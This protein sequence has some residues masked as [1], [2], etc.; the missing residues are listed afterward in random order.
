MRAAALASLSWGGSFHLDI[1]AANPTAAA[2][3]NVTLYVVD[4]ERFGASLVIKAMDLSTLKTIAPMAFVTPDASNGGAYIRYSVTGGVRFR[5]EQVHAAK[6]D[7]HGL[8]PRPMV[9]AVFFDSAPLLRGAQ[10]RSFPLY[11]PLPTTGTTLRTSDA[12]LQALWDRAASVEPT[13]ARPF[14][15]EPPFDVIIEGAQYKGVSDPLPHPLLAPLTRP[16]AAPGVDRDAAD[17]GRDVGRP[18]RAPCPQRAARLRPLPAQRR[19]P[20]PRGVALWRQ[21]AAGRRRAGRAELHCG[22]IRP[23]RWLVPHSAGRVLRLSG[24]RRRVV[25]RHGQPHQRPGVP[26]R[27]CGV[28]RALRQVFMVHA[29]RLAVRRVANVGANGTRRQLPIVSVPRR[30]ESPRL[31]LGGRYE[32]RQYRRLGGGPQHQV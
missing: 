28:T 12:G 21:P 29:Q 24:G 15:T 17:G 25:R 22:R 23:V 20:A 7:R 32:G 13:N 9:S 31:A 8:P 14:L 26:R 4:Y 16:A 19:P 11:D 30:S 10:T 27:A 3:H 18:R 1:Q 5:L 6:S 2:S